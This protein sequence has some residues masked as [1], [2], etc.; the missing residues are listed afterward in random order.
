MSVVEFDK[1]LKQI[2]TKNVLIVGAGVTGRPAAKLF[3][4]AGFNVLVLDEKK[5]SEEVKNQIQGLEVL[6]E[7]RV[8]T[9]SVERLK[10]Y[11]F[12]FAILSPGISPR[13]NLGHALGELKI[14][15]YTELDI[16]FPFLG[17]PAIAVT[18]TNGKTTVVHLI[19]QM[20]QTDFQNTELVGNV[21]FS[22]LS[23]LTAEDLFVENLPIKEKSKTWVA[24]L[25][26]YQ[27]E[28]VLSIKPKVSLLLNIDDD[29]LERHGTLEAYVAAKARIFTSQD[30]DCWSIMNRD[31]F[32]Y[33][34]VACKAKGRV[35]PF[36]K[37]NRWEDSNKIDGSYFILET[38]EINFVLNGKSEEYSLSKTRLVGIHNKLNLAAAIAA[39]R[40]FGASISAIQNVIDNFIPL[41][42]RIEL[43]RVVNGV[44]YVNDSK[45]T[46]VSAVMVALDMIETEFPKGKVILLVG[47]KIKEGSWQGIRKR[48]NQKVRAVIAFGG[49]REL[50]LE[51]L[52]LDKTKESDNLIVKSIES[53]EYAVYEANIL[54][55]PGDVVL[56]SPGC[57][58]F[59]AFKDYVDR[60]HHFKKYVAGL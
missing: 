3:S 47:G 40:L 22:F 41:E 53:L 4:Q 37:L 43:V 34:D 31:E 23:K 19:E 17:M 8:T 24:E 57:A 56:L 51:R 38:N 33:K 48:I 9:E 11:H 16:A 50:V 36:G 42:H 12:A 30:K 55:L 49:D 21:G 18:G 2:K 15:L 29:H 58:S 20:L 5:L 25:S 10:E 54:A 13:G 1:L 46:N 28:G 39:A 44:S 6:E 52:G 60:G 7:F 45:G 32:W 14:P 26:S 59:D 35:F 27:L